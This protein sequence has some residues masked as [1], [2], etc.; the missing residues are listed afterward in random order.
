[1]TVKMTQSML[2]GIRGKRETTKGSTASSLSNLSHA[3]GGLNLCNK[4]LCWPSIA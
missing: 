2:E 3:A 4:A 1:M